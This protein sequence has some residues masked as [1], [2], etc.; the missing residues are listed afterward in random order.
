M[1]GAA[2]DA[3]TSESDARLV[4]RVLSGE[5]HA[6]A[7]LVSRYAAQCTRYADRVLR[8]RTDAEDTVQETFI[9][10]YDALA[11]YS[12][13]A[14]F[15]AWLFT[16]LINQCRRNAQQRNRRERLA[17][18][19]HAAL[20]DAPDDHTVVQLERDEQMEHVRDALARLEPLLREAFLLRHV[21]GF[22]YEEMRIMTGAGVSALKMRVKRACD[23]LR[24][25]LEVINE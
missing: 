10:A 7:A 21:E 16:I 14:R 3:V 11:H 1:T 17:V 6:Y 4:E 25:H 5:T 13:Q 22:D 15:G 23:A 18:S 8:D 2:R 12:E 19:D 20:L 9:S 24:V